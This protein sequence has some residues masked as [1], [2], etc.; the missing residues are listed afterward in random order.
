MLT[1]KV[2]NIACSTVAHKRASTVAHKRASTVAHIRG[3]GAVR[4]EDAYG[5]GNDRD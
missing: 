2:S 4:K 1:L 3:S 5:E